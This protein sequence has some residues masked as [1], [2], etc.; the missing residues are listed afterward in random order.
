VALNSLT[1][2]ANWFRRDSGGQD[3]CIGV[4]ELLLQATKLE[5]MLLLFGGAGIDLGVLSFCVGV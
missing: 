4:V 1:R 5:L 3:R 2:C